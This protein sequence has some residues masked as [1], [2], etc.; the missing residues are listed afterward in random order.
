VKV[1]ILEAGRPPRALRPRFGGYPA[2]VE[3][4]LA[5]GGHQWRTY[6][7]AAGDLPAAPDTC[8]AYVVTGAS[9]GVYDPE[10]W[11]AG[12]LDF[13]RAARG[14]A[15]LVGI[16]F[17][18]QAMAQAFGGQVIK[19][20]KGWG[21]GLHRYEVRQMRAWMDPP[22]SFALP[23][24]HQDQVVELPPGA[25]VLAGS[26][27]CPF[28]MLA[29]DD[30]PSISLQP[31][32]EFTPEFA[33]ALIEGRRGTA[34]PE[35]LARAAGHSLAQPDDGARVGRWINRFLASANE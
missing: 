25:T 18:H 21:V 10:P 9:A 22:P 29:Y 15:A 20:P 17:G 7:V 14:R 35:D 26:D 34:V 23:A 19:S 32:P 5:G 33:I 11:I 3:T 13:L 16:C 2:M 8:E 31:H 1:G 28:A 30:H 27:F 12:L 6:D 24:S 4:L